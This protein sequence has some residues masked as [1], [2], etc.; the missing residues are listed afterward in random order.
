MTKRT[1]KKTSERTK[2]VTSEHTLE[3]GKTRTIIKNEST[4]VLDDKTKVVGK[5]TSEDSVLP[6]SKLIK[7]QKHKMKNKS[8]KKKCQV[9]HDE[10]II[11][12]DLEIDENLP[13]N[14]QILMNKLIEAAEIDPTDITIPT[15][16]AKK[17]NFVSVVNQAQQE[18]S[19]ILTDNLRLYQDQ[20]LEESTFQENESE[21]WD[22]IQKELDL[23]DR[24]AKLQKVKKYFNRVSN[25]KYNNDSLQVAKDNFNKA[26]ESL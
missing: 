1:D 5:I 22:K 6:S 4:N 23:K 26:A 19:G 20:L 18:L 2:E 15:T 24:I 12:P 8:K 9:L 25:T 10:E 14:D 16:K 17:A 3:F 13:T 21:W 7:D 11:E